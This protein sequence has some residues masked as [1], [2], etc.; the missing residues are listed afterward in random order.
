MT[1]EQDTHEREIVEAESDAS[2]GIDLS[3]VVIGFNE[4]Q[5]LRDCLE[6][7][8]NADLEGLR[9]ELIYV[10]GGSSDDSMAIARDCGVERILGGERRRRAA[11]NRNLGATQSR[12][13]FIQFLDGD[14]RLEPTWPK[15]AKAYLEEQPDV[16]VVCGRLLEVNRGYLFQVIQLDWV[17]REGAVETCGG[18][19]LFRRAPFQEAGAFP[20]DVAYGEEPLLCWRIRNQIKMEVHF[21]IEPMA[22]HDIGF[23]G[24]RDYWKQYRRNGATYIEIA[25][26]CAGTEDPYWT[27]DTVTNFAWAS[28]ILAVI[29]FLI[30]GSATVRIGIALLILLIGLRK[31]VQTRRRGVSWAIAL[32]YTAHVYGSKIPLAWG[33]LRWLVERAFRGGDAR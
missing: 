12:G 27:R 32:G 1:A 20:E 18:A 9:Y 6:S 30:A 21:W 24:F 16:A 25:A 33:Q 7:V 8:R 23:S 3:F 13:T 10:D 28:G 17:Q 14:M 31:I 2:D 5:H 19:A 26:R 22:L 29:A 11:E 15:R 4:A